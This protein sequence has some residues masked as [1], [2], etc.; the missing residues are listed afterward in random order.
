MNNQT[1]QKPDQ[2]S[3]IVESGYRKYVQRRWL[4]IVLMPLAVLLTGF[5]LLYGLEAANYLSGIVKGT[6]AAAVIISALAVLFQIVR[7]LPSS[8]FRDYY[9]RVSRHGGVEPLRNLLDLAGDF[10]STGGKLKNAAVKQNLQLLEQVDLDEKL[11]KYNREAGPSALI[12]YGLYVLMIPL[13]ALPV[14]IHLHPDGLNR[15]LQ[16]WKA[17]ERPN[18]YTYTIDPGSTI[19]EQ[20]SSFQVR[21]DFEGDRLPG[22]VHLS[23]RTGIE[24]RY[25]PQRMQKIGDNRFYSDFI[26]LF[27]DLDYYVEMDGFRS[28]VHQ[29]SVQLLPRFGDLVVAIDPPA[30][31]RIEKTVI[32]YPFSRIETY[33]GSTLRIKGRP[34]KPLDRN[35]LIRHTAA[36][37][38]VAGSE[39]GLSTWAF[40]VS[41]ADS[42]SFEMRDEYGLTNSNKFAFNLFALTDNPPIASILRPEQNKSVLNPENLEITYEVEDD[43]GFTG[44]RLRYS[45]VRAF[46]GKTE[47]GQAALATPRDRIHLGRYNWDLTGLRLQ[48][49]DRVEYWIEVT[50]NDEVSGYKTARSATHVLQSASLAEYLLDQDEKEQS[51]SDAFDNAR[52]EFEEMQRELDELRKNLRENPDDSWQSQRMIEDV[53]ERSSDLSEQ[54]QEIQKEFDELRKELEENNLLSEETLQKY[55][56]LRDLMEEIDDPE[57]RKALEELQKSLENMDQNQLREAM[58]KLDFN[59]QTYKERLERTIELFKD[60]RL[61]ADLEKTARLLEELS[62]QEERLMEEITNPDE[63]IQQQQMIRDEIDQIRD[64]L[65][66]LPDVGPQK[67]RNMTE[68]LRD[69]VG[70]DLGE[71]SE[72]IEQNM[73]DIDDGADE[74]QVRESQ[75]QIQQKLQQL[76]ED[77]R[78]SIQSMQQEQIT[79]NVT[80]LQA[81][82]QNLILLSESQEDINEI[83]RRLT[84]NSSAFITQARKQNNISRSFSQVSDSLFRVSAEIPQFSNRIN[85]KKAEV[86]RNLERA[87]GFQAERDRARSSAQ[88]RLSLGGI[89][90]LAVMVADL[91]EQIQNSDGSGGGGM[92]AQ[93][94]LQ[95][96]QQMGKDQQQLNQQI[97]D[98]INDMQGERL[99]QDQM[100]RLDQMARQQNR[101]RRQLQQMR[102]GG[103]LRPGDQMMSELQRVLEQ[104]EDTIN[105]LRGGSTDR[106]LVERQQNI[107]SRMLEAERAL[108]ERGEDDERRGETVTDFERRTPDELTLEEL[109]QRIRSSLQDPNQTRFSQDYQR[110]IERYFELLQERMSRTTPVEGTR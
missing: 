29:L 89:N 20:G 104:M 54:I 38:L 3:R 28:E 49:L 24:N 51:V 44:L 74:N 33:P 43:F 68:Q 99:S 5:A 12:T 32:N 27:N 72:Q 106:I 78:S 86:M 102:E 100:E 98:F 18:P 53:Q 56:E 81:I 10:R 39:E 59:E 4:A 101:I 48:P 79:I 77:V 110:L 25:R 9:Y 75:Q 109:Q 92:S 46:G 13:I 50:D 65:D 69:D 83:T 91:L 21:I 63:Q 61:T 37:T 34:N 16:F 11:R 87:V 31:T 45:V 15:S 67:R 23:L 22:D 26:E 30:Y 2:V 105:D 35:Y 71:V 42:L 84:D 73:Q 36:D 82:L 64:K 80:A 85:E 19:L 6:V 8:G 95:Q 90:E 14:L 7:K 103:G 70:G 41:G 88:E 40:E 52:T 57:L 62:R 93:Q 17:F 76:S 66:K 58:Q 97:T 96:M 60:L 47:S 1:E 94:M 107:L 108:Q 55:N